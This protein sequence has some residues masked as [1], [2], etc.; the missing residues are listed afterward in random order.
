[1][2]F[3]NHLDVLREINEN[4]DSATAD[5]TQHEPERRDADMSKKPKRKNVRQSEFRVVARGVHRPKPD[6]S[7]LMQASLDF[8]LA[9][10]EQEAQS[11]VPRPSSG[12]SNGSA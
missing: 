2:E 6:I 7:R 10:K 3:T 4:K 9:S 8:Y 1:M 5:F 12:G 11:D